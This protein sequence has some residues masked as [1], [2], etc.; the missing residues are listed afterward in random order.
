MVCWMTPSL[1]DGGR[2]RRRERRKRPGRHG[3]WRGVL[4]RIFEEWVE[5]D[6]VVG[7]VETRVIEDVE[8]LDVEFEPEALGD[9]E[10][11]EDA[12]VHAGLERAD[13]NVAARGAEVG[14]VDVADFGDGI[15][16]RDTVFPGWRSG[17]PKAALLRTGLPGLTPSVPCRT[18][19]APVVLPTPP[20]GTS[21]LVMK[22][23]PP[24]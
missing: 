10:I 5:L 22:S 21:G 16:G 8:R 7:R 13:E 12:H 2:R 18:A 4:R 20:M 19:F 1:P 15:A 3:E 11:F 6:V 23:L 17:M 14:F 24:P 9:L